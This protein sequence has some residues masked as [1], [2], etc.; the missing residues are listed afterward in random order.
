MENLPEVNYPTENNIFHHHCLVSSNIV[1]KK[2]L[3]LTFRHIEITREIFLFLQQIFYNFYKSAVVIDKIDN[4]NKNKH[5]EKGF[6]NKQNLV[7]HHN[8]PVAP[9]LRT[10][11]VNRTCCGVDIT[12]IGRCDHIILVSSLT[13][14]WR[15]SHNVISIT[16]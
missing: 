8:Y 2:V 5:S 4:S 11:G 10:S 3:H 9:E 16:A 1:Y 14:T 15:I 6:R 7:M 13:V 12:A